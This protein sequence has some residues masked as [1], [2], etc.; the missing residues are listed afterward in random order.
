VV[1]SDVHVVVEESDRSRGTRLP[2]CADDLSVPQMH[3]DLFPGHICT[4]LYI[5]SM[6]VTKEISAM[7]NTTTLK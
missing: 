5:S 7:Y 1:R 6:L 4:I 2:V 3:T